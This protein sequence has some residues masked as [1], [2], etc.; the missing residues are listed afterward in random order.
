MIHNH[1]NKD[2]FF[3]ENDFGT[4]NHILPL[5]S[6]PR[7]KLLKLTGFL[8]KILQT[9][10]N[11]AIAAYSTYLINSY[12]KIITAPNFISTPFI[13]FDRIYNSINQL[14]SSVDG[15]KTIERLQLILDQLQ[16]EKQKILVL[17]NNRTIKQSIS[18]RQGSEGVKIPLVEKESLLKNIQ[19]Q[20]GS[21][22]KLNISLVEDKGNDSKIEIKFN[23]IISQINKIDVQKCFTA[24]KLIAEKLFASK[25][26]NN[27]LINCYFDGANSYDGIS[28]GAGL[29]VIFICSILKL[30]NYK[31]IF[32][33]KD[34]VAITGCIDEEGNFLPVAEDGLKIKSE[35]CFFSE[36]KYFIVPSVQKGIVI[37]KYREIEAEYKLKAPEVIGADNIS[38]IFFDRRLINQRRVSIPVRFSKK[39][40][41]YRRIIAA[42]VIVILLLMIFKLSY[43]PLDKNPVSAKLVGK[44][45]YIKNKNENNLAQIKLNIESA[46]LAYRDDMVSFGDVNNDGRNEV[47]W[48]DENSSRSYATIYCADVIAGDTLWKYDCIKELI[49]RS[50]P[51]SNKDFRAKYAK[52]IDA[53]NDGRDEV[54]VV[55]FNSYFPSYLAK[56]DAVT[57][58]EER[59]YLH[60]GHMQQ[61]LFVDVNNDSTQE[62]ILTAINNSLHGTA[63]MMLNPKS[64]SGYSP[65][66]PRHAI[67]RMNTGG[68][69]KYVFLPQTIIGKLMNRETNWSTPQSLEIVNEGKNFRVAIAEFTQII[70]NKPLSPIYYVNFNLNFDI[71]SFSTGDY[72]DKLSD[73]LYNSGAIK[74]HLDQEYFEEA[75]KLSVRVSV[76]Q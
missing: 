76:N 5:I 63:V 46:P 58:K 66:A 7:M 55:C 61:I 3:I 12:S 75:Y 8:E 31:E 56:L 23:N 53:D 51:V 14:S 11:A 44:T 39:V 28:F 69:L 57:G 4:L 18:G 13:F 41:R 2:L 9:E 6:S 26:K 74:R 19:P 36:V 20:F 71:S 45:L 54:Y 15:E 72:F 30:I 24:G 35:A 68:E 70:D 47:V 37:Q 52:I 38:E 64:F 32:S 48:I 40:W 65:H 62:I 33:F 42:F 10:N 1:E 16:R 49:C 60:D 27:L 59:F 21:L 73:A 29:T 17:I 34:D 25:V 50:D 67:E 43:G 22:N